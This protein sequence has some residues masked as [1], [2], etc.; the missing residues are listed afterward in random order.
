MSQVKKFNWGKF[1]IT[2]SE[3]DHPAVPALCSFFYFRDYVHEVAGELADGLE[4]YLGLVGL[5]TLKSYAAK[6][7]DWKPMTQRQLNRDV[8]QLR[9]FPKDHEAI[10]IRYDAGEGGEPGGFGV[11]ISANIRDEIFPNK[12][13]LLRVDL[14][15][16]WLEN[17]EV[18]EVIDFVSGTCQ[19]PHVESAQVGLTFKTTPGSLGDAKAE[20]LH[21]LPRYF[22]FSPC[23]FSLRNEMLGHTLTAHWLNYIDD[24]LAASVGGPR[25]IVKALPECDVRK[26]AKGVL[27]RGAKVPPIGDINQK[28]PDLG[29]LP[30]VARLLKPT[31]LDIGA[32]YLAHEGP[33]FNAAKWIGRLDDLD[34]RPWD[35][36]GAI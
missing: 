22:G 30:E 7:G 28:A 23:D 4:R 3:G 29:R 1:E 33:D 5:G 25:T 10:H 8:K 14:P 24:D 20:I 36:S 12:A 19:M 27:I 18:E 21:K 11:H 16:Q 17:H 2:D 9:D 6:S 15:P 35:N 26:L 34:P 13:G 32:T 31:R